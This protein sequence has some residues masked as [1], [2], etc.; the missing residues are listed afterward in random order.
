MTCK[1]TYRQKINV[2]AY[3]EAR[4]VEIMALYE[5]MSINDVAL[6]MQRH[7][8]CD[9]SVNRLALWMRKTGLSKPHR[10]R[11]GKQLKKYQQRPR[12]CQAC[13][14]SFV[15]EATKQR[16]CRICCPTKR[17]RVRWA[18]YGITQSQFEELMKKQD[19]R[20]SGCLHPFKDE[21][22]VGMGSTAMHIDHDHMTGQVRGM[23]C[24]ACNLSIGKLRDDPCTLRRL[25]EYLERAS[26]VPSNNVVS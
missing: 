25:A 13:K 14:V 11:G 6:E 1:L 7:G 23:L 20:C 3:M 22:N 18:V 4:R 21:R 5:T 9:M 26:V 8:H 2:H 24:G 17:A 19:S 16:C 12:S 10:L 15:P